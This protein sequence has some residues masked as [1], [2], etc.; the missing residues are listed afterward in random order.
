M[1]EMPKAI[2]KAKEKAR[3][4]FMAADSLVSG[5]FVK[6]LSSFARFSDASRSSRIHLE[7][8]SSPKQYG[9]LNSQ[10]TNDSEIHGQKARLPK[11]IRLPVALSAYSPHA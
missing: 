2:R 3:R 11:K 1:K 7:G 5:L 10:S 9:Q 6:R 4:G 8:A